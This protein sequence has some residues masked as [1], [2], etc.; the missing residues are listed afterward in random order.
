MS[1]KSMTGFARAEGAHEGTAWH[2]E[3]RSVNGRGLDVRL[4]LPSGSEPLEP[5][6]R[7]AVARHVVRGSLT[8]TL[9]TERSGSIAEIRLNERAL[10]QVMQAADRIRDL[11]NATPPRVDGLIAIKGVLDIVE[12][13]E[14]PEQAA[15]RADAMLESLDGALVALV[16]ARAAEGARLASTLLAQLDEIERLV[17]I[18][19]TSPART[20]EAIEERLKEQVRRLLEAGNGLDPTRLHQEAVL[21]ATRADVE[22]ELQRLTSHVSAAREL[23]AES[24]AV[25]RKLDFLAQ[26]FNRE[27]NT[28][29]S[30]ASDV[31]ITRA[32]LALK[33]V[34]DQLREQVQNIE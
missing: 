5:R 27:A 17:G 21:L 1:I 16:A 8:I 14:D 34:I 29:C 10:A 18:V 12:H 25:G 20:R 13:Q 7:E 31:E 11:T 28:L 32:G 2:W 6:V 23:I 33:T 22:E 15:A 9:A 3:V 26:E 30:K 19:Q 4:R 24:G